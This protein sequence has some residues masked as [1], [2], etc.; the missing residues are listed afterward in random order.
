[1]DENQMANIFGLAHMTDKYRVTM[2]TSKENCFNVH[3]EAGVIK[4]QRTPENL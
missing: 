1:V 4:F 2:D 3:T